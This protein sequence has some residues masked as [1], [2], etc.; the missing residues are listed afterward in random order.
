[1]RAKTIR[2]FPVPV[3]NGAIY[4]THKDFR[5]MVLYTLIL[6]FCLVIFFFF[7]MLFLVFLQTRT[8][9][10]LNLNP[11]MEVRRALQRHGRSAAVRQNVTLTRHSPFPYPT[12]TRVDHKEHLM[13]TITSS[14]STIHPV[15]V[16]EWNNLINSFQVQ[17]QTHPCTRKKLK[18]TRGCRESTQNFTRG[19]IQNYQSCA[20]ERSAQK[21]KLKSSKCLG[22]QKKTPKDAR[23]F[24]LEV[25]FRVV[26]SYI[27][28][29]FSFY[30]SAIVVCSY[31]VCYLVSIVQLLL[32][33][34]TL[35]YLLSTCHQPQV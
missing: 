14:T 25:E 20:S 31:I 23:V 5:A 7:L 35:S 16:R 2:E 13:Y 8:V 24:K 34:H 10:I 27:A 26:R 19:Y 12:S 4:W 15:Q 6:L 17:F 1:M 33:V 9:S 32:F 3:C 11:W 22:V 18:S 28:L 21:Y 29:L 30:C